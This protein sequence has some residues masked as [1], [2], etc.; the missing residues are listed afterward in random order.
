MTPSNG[1][2]V[3][4]E[5]CLLLVAHFRNLLFNGKNFGF[6]TRLFSHMLHP[7]REF[8]FAGKSTK[9]DSDTPTH[10][11]HVVPC[12]VLVTECQRL[13]KEGQ[14]SD[15]E[16]ARLLQ[17]HWRVAAITRDEQKRLDSDLKLK[18]KMPDGWTFDN[19]DTFA[20]FTVAQIELIS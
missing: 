8:V 14:Y 20:R 19:G 9:V 15:P 4:Y 3:V 11:E 1:V 13:I 2:D 7:E 16:I 6:H 12:A 18:S 5:T 17:K 10:P